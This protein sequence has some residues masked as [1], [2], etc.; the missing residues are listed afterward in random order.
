M[1]QK[2]RS[3]A[4]KILKDIFFPKPPTVIQAYDITS[5]LKRHGGPALGH[6]QII[7]RLNAL[8]SE[9]ESHEVPVR[10]ADLVVNTTNQ[11]WAGDYFKRHSSAIMINETNPSLLVNDKTFLPSFSRAIFKG[12]GVQTTTDCAVIHT[13]ADVSAFMQ[14]NDLTQIALKTGHGIA[15]EGV[16]RVYTEATSGQLMIEDPHAEDKATQPTSVPLSEEHIDSEGMLAMRWLEPSKG[17]IR[18]VIVNGECLGA[19]KRIAKKDSWLCNHAQGGRIVSVDLK[20]AFSKNDRRKLDAVGQS[21]K[22]LGIHHAALDWLSDGSGERFLSEINV[23]C[24]D[25]LIEIHAHQSP[26]A[27]KN[28]LFS[29]PDQWLTPFSTII[30]HVNSGLPSYPLSS[31]SLLWFAKSRKL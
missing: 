25:D 15:G 19:Y 2:P 8:F 29:K 10:R 6:D 17:D 30:T 28:G 26:K 13:L 22:E 5:L 27:L 20:R 7:R 11:L 23:G 31:R 14:T 4:E 21:L 18:T 12:C 3:H 16:F 1:H 9:T 24:T